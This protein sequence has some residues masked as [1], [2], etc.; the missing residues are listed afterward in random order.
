MFGLEMPGWTDL[1]QEERRRVATIVL[2]SLLRG[3]GR[4]CLTVEEGQQCLKVSHNRINYP[5]AAA[6]EA[7]KTIK[8]AS[9]LAKSR[10]HPDI[11]A[12]AFSKRTSEHGSRSR[13]PEA[14]SASTMSSLNTVNSGKRPH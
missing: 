8:L 1:C 2:S 11:A 10:W 7:G 4:V 14:T 13:S 3:I 9:T 5:S 12:F 6:N